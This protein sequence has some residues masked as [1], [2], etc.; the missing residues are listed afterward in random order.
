MGFLF[1]GV[2]NAIST[3]F[4]NSFFK[5]LPKTS[6]F[7]LNW[8]RFLVAIVIIGTLVTAFHQWKLPHVLTF[9]LLL[10]FVSL[11]MELGQSYF[12]VT[13]FQRSPQSIIGP[14]FSLSALFL[15]P[16]SYVVLGEL[17]SFIGLLGIASVMLGPFFLGWQGSGMQLGDAVKNVFREPGTWRMLASAFFAAL[18]VTFAKFSYRYVPPLLFAF[19]I[20]TALA[21]A[22][23]VVLLFKRTPPQSAFNKHIVWMS[24]SYGIGMV[25]HYIGLSLALAAYYISV[26]RLSIVFDVIF[27]RILHKEDHFRERFVGALLM[28]IG[29]ILI[30]FG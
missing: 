8:F 5:R 11:P 17:P 24:V 19:Y 16:L 10:I 28:V 21:I 23:S 15:V 22:M 26:K 4:Q 7:I 13:A 2:A 30:A 18:A 9:W 20:T 1:Y 14:L 3:S 29:I 25:F 6:P 27:G 12:Y